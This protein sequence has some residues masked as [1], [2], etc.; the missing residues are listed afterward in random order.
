MAMKRAVNTV[1]P[2]PWQYF[3]RLA[4]VGVTYWVAAR[5]SLNLALVHG[6]VTPLW[7]PTGIALVAI[8]VLGRGVAPGIALAAFAV[9]LPLGPSPLGAAFIAVG[10]TLAPLLSAELLARAGFRRE[11]D[12]IRDAVVLIVLGA[13]VGMMVSATVGTLVLV[14]SGAVP[15]ARLAATWAVWWTG[16]AMGVLLVAP[17][18]LNL[19]P[20]PG[21]RPLSWRGAIEVALVSAGVGLV[22]Y[23]LFQNRFRL[24]YL[25]LPLIMAAAW[26]FRLRGAEP[27]GLVAS[28]VAIWVAVHADVPFAHLPLPEKVVPLPA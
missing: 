5:L 24:E 26:R 20:S 10:N 3:F 1:V 27:A 12:R 19:L 22:T 23:V 25:V 4:L 7:P 6:Q 8:L 2:K 17:F 14:L 28:V 15:A 11:L 13:L 16:D 21:R 9:N 18:L